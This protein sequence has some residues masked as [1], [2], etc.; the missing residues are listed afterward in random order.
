MADNSNSQMI[1]QALGVNKNLGELI[2]VMRAV[3]VGNSSQGQ[4]TCAAAGST[5]V[6]DANVKATSHIQLQDINATAATLQGSAK[7]LYVDLATIIPGVSFV[8]K[9][10]SSSAAGTEKFSYIIANVA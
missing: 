8:V 3:F 9:T 4:F 5:T 6:T 10:A 1:G 2:S 7:R